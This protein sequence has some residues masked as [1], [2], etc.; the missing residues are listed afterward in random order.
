[1]KIGYV[2]YSK[3]L[4]HPADRRRIGILDGIEIN[5]VNPLES[6]LLL[7]SNDANFRWWMKRAKQHVVLDLVDGYLGESPSI[8]K[9]ALRNVIRSL[10]GKSS[11]SW[12]LYTRHLKYAALNATAIIVGSE[13]QRDVILPYNK[14]VF[15]IPDDHSEIDQYKLLKPHMNL[16]IG[17][18]RRFLFWEGYGYTFK[19]FKHISKELDVFLFENNLSLCLVTTPVFHRWG[20]YI[21]KTRIRKLVDKWFPLSSKNI[22]VVPWNLENLIFYSSVSCFGIIPINPT[23]K[24]ARLKPENKLVSMWRLGLPTFS[25]D[26]PS[27][28]RVA[29]GAGVAELIVSNGQWAKKASQVLMGELDFDSI[30][31]KQMFFMQK[32]Y[33]REKLQLRWLKIFEMYSG[34]L[35]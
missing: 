15:V 18:E 2:G 3:T 5:T 33:S 14:N 20:G 28:V 21:G 12:V 22:L 34:N 13:E 16:R 27:Y 30:R 25:S 6:D 31:R 35:K 19:H 24:F 10:A 1:M 4:E 29:K 11:F 8:A 7:L 23:D 26:I 17:G 9:D 32:H